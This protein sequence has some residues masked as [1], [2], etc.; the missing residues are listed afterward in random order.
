MCKLFQDA[1][2]NRVPDLCTNHAMGRCTYGD[3]CR[4]NHDLVSYVQSKPLDLPGTCPWT[5]VQSTCPYGMS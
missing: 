4:F 1:R 2:A 3:K 5:A